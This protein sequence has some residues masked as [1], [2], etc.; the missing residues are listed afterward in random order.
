MDYK[1]P[2]STIVH[3]G[4]G[5]YP[6]TTADQ[7][8][9]ADGSRLEKDGK[10]NVDS[11]ANASKLGGK[12]PKY[13]IQPRNLL[14]N[15]DFTNPVNQRGKTSYTGDNYTIDRWYG[16]VNMQSVEVRNDDVTVTANALSY[17]GI[18]QKIANIDRLAG[19]T[20]TLAAYVYS[21]VGVAV[22]FTDADDNAISETVDDIGSGLRVILCTCTIPSNATP[23]TFIPRI[24]LLTTAQ[25]DYMR[26]YWAALYEGS[27]T[28]ETLPPYVPKGYAAELAECQRYYYRMNL[29]NAPCLGTGWAYRTN[30]RIPIALPMTMRITP[31]VQMDVVSNFQIIYNKA[32]YSATNISIQN[33]TFNHLTLNVVADTG[34]SGWDIVSSRINSAATIEFSADL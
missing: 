20:V 12:A 10:I 15:S 1:K 30:N 24:L 27:Y 29:N 3:G 32:T 22:G 8:I 25:N 16:R 6:L 9:L 14:D 33:C 5:I 31:T 13:Y 11:A 34:I 18:K 2:Q 19:K 26:C 17:V 4:A 21:T 28:A 23:D 7:V